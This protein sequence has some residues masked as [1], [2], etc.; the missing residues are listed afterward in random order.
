MR[1]IEGA[2][3][4]LARVREGRFASKVLRDSGSAMAPGDLSLAA[5]LVYI[6]LR[7][8]EMWWHIVGGFLRS[9]DSRSRGGGGRSPGRPAAGGRLPPQIADCLLVGAAGLLELRH[10]AGG[11][12]VNGLLEHLKNEGQGRFV[13]LANAVLHAVG[14]RCLYRQVHSL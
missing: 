1:G 14:E 11:V 9:G 7:R 13:S 8:E 3:H 6:V 2:L 12:L 4:V 5:S 10:F